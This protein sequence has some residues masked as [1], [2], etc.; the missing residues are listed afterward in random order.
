MFNDLSQLW[1]NE[2]TYFLISCKQLAYI[3]ANLYSNKSRKFQ[4]S[5]HIQSWSNSFHYLSNHTQRDNNDILPK[6]YL[7]LI[8]LMFHKI[9]RVFPPQ[10]GNR[11]SQNPAFS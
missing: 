7:A 9:F 6:H 2:S 3:F 5:F 1:K 11:G 8:F 4:D 10:E